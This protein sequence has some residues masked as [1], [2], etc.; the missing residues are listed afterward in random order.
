LT[1]PDIYEKDLDALGGHEEEEEVGG[2]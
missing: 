1:Y 2:C